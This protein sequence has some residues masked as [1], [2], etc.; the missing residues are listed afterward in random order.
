M[1]E[2]VL[3]VEAFNYSQKVETVLIMT[4]CGYAITASAVHV[5]PLVDRRQLVERI[6]EGI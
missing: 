6:Y 5:G 1:L 4:S 3:M 2:S